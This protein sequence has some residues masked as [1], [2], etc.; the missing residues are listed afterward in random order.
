MVTM[1]R[2][3]LYPHDQLASTDW[4]MEIKNAPIRRMFNEGLAEAVSAIV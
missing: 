1:L 3:G 2:M 4:S